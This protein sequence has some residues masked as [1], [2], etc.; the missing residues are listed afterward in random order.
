VFEAEGVLLASYRGSS[1]LLGKRGIVLALVRGAR[2]HKRSELLR[3]PS[4]LPL[5][6]PTSDISG[7]YTEEGP[8]IGERRGFFGLLLVLLESL[9]GVHA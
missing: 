4:E 9:H 5:K 8:L 1:A 7:E 6:S 3:Y 2:G